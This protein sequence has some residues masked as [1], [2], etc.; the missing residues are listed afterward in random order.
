VDKF[1]LSPA[2]L[3]L[4]LRNAS[5]RRAHECGCAIDN[6]AGHARVAWRGRLLERAAPLL[7]VGPV[8]AVLVAFVVFGRCQRREPRRPPT[9]GLR[10]SLQLAALDAKVP[11]RGKMLD[12]TGRHENFLR[13]FLVWCPIFTLADSVF[14][15]PVGSALAVSR[16]PAILFEGWLPTGVEP[17]T[18]ATF[19]DRR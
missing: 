7:C 3:T 13:Q 17:A 11:E 4:M 8:S 9:A 1:F 6:A 10:L 14:A 12:D 5:E 19:A 16:L 18:A 2:K 15:R